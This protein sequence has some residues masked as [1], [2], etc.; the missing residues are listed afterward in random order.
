MYG[1]GSIYNSLE[2]GFL[3]GALAPIPFYFLA[4]RYPRSWVHYIHIP[5]ILNGVT[6]YCPY[7]ISYVTPTVMVGFA[8][9]Y[10]IK[11]RYS[12]WWQKYAYVL[13]SSFSAGIAIAAIII[14]FAVQYKET[15][16][17]WWGN[18]V[19]YAGCDGAG[20]TLL[21]IPAEGHF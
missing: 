1:A 3:A 7:N 14:F 11:R 15:P 9:N 8:F 5:L 21:P 19:S 4:R 17:V 18:T 20:C 12:L 2:W 10:Y 6:W 13:T 16:L